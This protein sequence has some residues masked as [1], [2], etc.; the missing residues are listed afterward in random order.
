[1]CFITGGRIT[2]APLF[3]AA[4]VGPCPAWGRL[5]GSVT[6][7]P[8]RRSRRE[9]GGGT[10]DY[11]DSTCVAPFQWTRPERMRRQRAICA[12]AQ[13][14][15]PVHVREATPPA[16]AHGSR[17]AY[18]LQSGQPQATAPET[19]MPLP[20]AL[21]VGGPP[22]QPALPQYANYWAPLTRKRHILPHPA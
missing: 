12:A 15:A 18:R 13:H 8:T 19:Q 14:S 10:S 17:S 11:H 3:A 21:C 9:G 16:I 4:P 20:V 1:M 7:A 5:H 2:G 6:T 22:P